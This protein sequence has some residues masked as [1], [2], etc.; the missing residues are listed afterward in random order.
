MILSQC[1]PGSPILS[2]MHPRPTRESQAGDLDRQTG[3]GDSP[4]VGNN[5]PREGRKE[6][7]IEDEEDNGNSIQ[8]G[9]G[10]AREE[11]FA[12]LRALPVLHGG[13]NP[14]QEENP[15]NRIGQSPKNRHDI[16]PF[17]FKKSI[18]Q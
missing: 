9:I 17:L 3:E 11:W 14:E 13:N 16:F 18:R 2:Q 7:Q 5:P 10:E 6:A 15:P 8:D 4:S 1:D 12:L